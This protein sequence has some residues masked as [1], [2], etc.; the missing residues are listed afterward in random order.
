M[1]NDV[2]RAFSLLAL[3]CSVLPGTAP[4]QS[5]SLSGTVVSTQGEKPIA[6]AEIIFGNLNRTVR[7]DSA[8][9]FLVPNIPDGVQEVLVRHVGYEPFSA[10]MTF[11]GAEKVSADFVL[12]SVTTLATV[13]VKESI[14]ARYAMRLADFEIRR[15]MG[16]GKFIDADYFEKNDM[17]TWTAIL[18][19]KFG[20]LRVRDMVGNDV[21]VTI[22]D[23]RP[24]PVQILL[25]GMTLYNGEAILFDI[26][27]LQ[28]SAV[29]GM[30]FYT[31]L[32]T[33]V[34]F[35]TRPRG[36]SG[37]TG[38]GTLLIWTK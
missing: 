24:C 20:T 32:F 7:A 2:V 29:I 12:N 11:R 14:K 23:G 13:D 6:N 38:C 37:G 9:R 25:N 19:Q 1:L 15:K 4:A 27:S 22:R 31:P 26:R 35:M 18:T 10:R 28:V 33:P 5:G 34:E 17:M 3:L 8:G 21:P 36:S 16:F 30:E